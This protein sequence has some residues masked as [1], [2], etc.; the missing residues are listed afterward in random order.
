M[1]TQI[2]NHHVP[3]AAQRQYRV[4]SSWCSPFIIVATSPHG[5]QAHRWG[6]KTSAPQCNF[7][8]IGVRRSRSISLAQSGVTSSISLCYIKKKDKFD[9]T[10]S[11]TPYVHP[12]RDPPAIRL[13]HM[14]ANNETVSPQVLQISIISSKLSYKECF[15]LHN[16][17]LQ[18]I[19]T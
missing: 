17:P 9:A 19:L 14:F 1:R 4:T 11:S 10:L 5:T 18:Q 3:W 13:Q 6:E 16:G 15:L 12:Y 7:D 2:P 8:N